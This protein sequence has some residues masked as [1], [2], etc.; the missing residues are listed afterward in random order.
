MCRWTVLVGA[1]A[2][3]GLLGVLGGAGCGG[4]ATED[5]G[6]GT[7]AGGHG[8]SSLC[9]ATPPSSGSACTPPS[10]NT[11][12]DRAH[13]SWG[14]DPRP[15]CRTSARCQD[16]G[17]WWVDP[18]AAGCAVPPL[19][20]D[21]PSPP[22]SV[23]T[24][25]A[26]A[27]LACWYADGER[28]W[29]SE[30]QGGSEYPICQTIDP[31]EWACAS[32]PAG[33]PT[34]IPQAGAP[35]STPG[36]SCGPDCELEVV[37]EDGSWLWRQGDCP[38]CAAPGTPIATPAGEVAI[39][40]LRPG[41]LVYSVDGDAIVAV[42]V[43]RVASTPVARHR[44]VRVE[45]QDGAVLEVSP[46]HPTADGHLFA[47]LHTGSMLDGHRVARAELVPYRYARTYDILPDSDTGSYFAAGARIGSTLAPE[48]APGERR[49]GA[50][51]PP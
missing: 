13:C 9:P 38:I 31:P 6:G 16:D 35:C 1:L 3:L 48:R 21:C 32:P 46:G 5:G 20:S 11:F 29:C 4:T 14:D 23:G 22:P 30:C 33:C 36:L 18:P 19:P 37:C 44:V 25:C 28:C 26:D 2:A 43:L 40:D 27:T 10:D 45:L 8:S 42:A 47:D 50:A 34:V 17:S 24:V 12:Y 41:D 39:A 49:G 15:D 7:A 51:S